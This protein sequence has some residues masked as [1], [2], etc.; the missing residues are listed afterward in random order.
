LTL[1]TA[2]RPAKVV[3]MA[4]GSA[5]KSDY[6]NGTL[7]VQLPAAKRTKLVDVVQVEFGK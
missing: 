2:A 6:A 5:L 1:T 7:T 4:D 3:L